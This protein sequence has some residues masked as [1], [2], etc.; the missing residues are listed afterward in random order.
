[1]E[2]VKKTRLRFSDTD[3]LALLREVL[4]QN[5]FIDSRRW[6]EV[7]SNMTLLTGKTFKEKTL[8]DHLNLLIKL[9]LE[10]KKILEGK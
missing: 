7:A 5:P 4:G 10:N 6:S 2:M 8:R 3:D 9:W 1:M